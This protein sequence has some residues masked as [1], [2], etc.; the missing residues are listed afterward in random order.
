M[1]SG[2]SNKLISAREAAGYLGVSKTTVYERYEEWGLPAYWVGANLRFRIR[3]IELW[4]ERRRVG[5][6]QDAA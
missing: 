3:D 4:L 5:G 6:G 1:S 2:G